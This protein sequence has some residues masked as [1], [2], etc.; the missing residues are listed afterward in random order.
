VFVVFRVW[1]TNTVY[2]LNGNE[3]RNYCDAELGCWRQH[4]GPHRVYDDDT[5][6]MI[7]DR[8]TDGRTDTS[9]THHRASPCC[10]VYTS[11]VFHQHCAVVLQR[12]SISKSQS[13][14]I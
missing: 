11:A 12:S 10:S 1:T 9:T 13:L 8:Q 14:M 3:P 2:A 7:D 4:G 5:V 6:A